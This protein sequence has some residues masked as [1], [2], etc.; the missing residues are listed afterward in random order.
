LR[1]TVY[2]SQLN[3]DGSDEKK[4]NSCN[5]VEVRGSRFKNI[6]KLLDLTYTLENIIQYIFG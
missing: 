6:K 3:L 5:N 1:K 2:F 4:K